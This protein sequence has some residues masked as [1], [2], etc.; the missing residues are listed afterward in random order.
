MSITDTDT[1]IAGLAVLFS[2]GPV[3]IVVLLRN[4]VKKQRQA[5]IG[6]LR[7]I[8]HTSD[9]TALAAC[10]G[11]VE[12]GILSFEFV[13]FKYFYDSDSRARRQNP[14]QKKETQDVP[15]SDWAIAAIPLIIILFT[16]N[17]L[18][19]S[20]LASA[21]LQ[22]SAPLIKWVASSQQTPLYAWVLLA[23]YAAA[24]IY[25]EQEFFRAINN[26]DLSPASFVEASINIVT[27]VATAQVFCFGLLKLPEM[28]DNSVALEVTN[29][30]A[31]ISAFAVGYFPAVAIRNLIKTS[32]LKDYKS[33][34]GDIFDKFKAVPVE[35][36]DGIDTEIRDRL[37]DFH[38]TSVQNLAT[39]NPIMLFVE[40]PYGVYQIMD[41]VAQAQ[42]CCSVGPKALV[43][44]WTLGVR[45]L[46]DLERVAL[47]RACSDP[48]LLT[49]IGK[50]ILPDS[51]IFDEKAVVAN[52]KMRLEHPYVHRLC[53]IYTCVGI[54]LGDKHRRL[55]PF[56]DCTPRDDNVCPF[57]K[58]RPANIVVKEKPAE[59]AAARGVF[60]ILA[61]KDE[62]DID[63]GHDA[64]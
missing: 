40:T 33:V 37:A 12:L 3:T 15:F 43:D 17:F 1:V 56:I 32:K 46:F 35:V 29:T 25:M 48:A 22:D 6:D 60:S 28:Y 58:P 24:F 59:P 7:K 49:A 13:K 2:I 50:I 4:S 55:P 21:A 20:T 52:I 34:A 30:I 16:L 53:Q 45:T 27:G 8:F 14:G 51:Q 23:S 26:F 10:P 5:V 57:V 19:F 44:L 31:L 54:H 64:T 11:E 63:F 47:D 41:W 38:I 61:K 18:V 36:I 9:P 62:A 42:L 39:A